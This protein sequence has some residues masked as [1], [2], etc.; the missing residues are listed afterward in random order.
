MREPTR[1]PLRKRPA[2]PAPTEGPVVRAIERM[3][4]RRTDIYA[5][6]NNTG[7]YKPTKGNRFIRY[8]HKGSADFLG[9]T[10]GG[11]FIALEAKRPDGGVQSKSQR[12]F[13]EKVLEQGGI[14]AIVRSVDE[15]MQVIDEAVGL[16][17]RSPRGGEG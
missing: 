5:W 13:E 3:L 2:P 12:E 7:A 17:R 14:Y 6:R 16:R 1:R 15:A 10:R 11:R 4:R 9:V 8:G